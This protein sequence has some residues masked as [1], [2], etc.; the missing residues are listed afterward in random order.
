MNGYERK[1]RL[2]RR[3]YIIQFGE[4]VEGLVHGLGAELERIE[5][6]AEAGGREDDGAHRGDRN[7]LEDLMRGI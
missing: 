3:G 7:A 4:E 6:H 5:V 2:L 1:R